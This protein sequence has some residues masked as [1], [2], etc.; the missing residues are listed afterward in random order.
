MRLL[1]N[2]FLEIFDESIQRQYDIGMITLA[3]T[4]L[5]N[6]GIKHYILAW[7]DEFKKYI[8]NENLIH[9]DWGE[10]SLKYPD[11]MGSSHTSEIGQKEVFE[12][13]LKKIKNKKIL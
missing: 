6:N 7:D 8:P 11:E 2:Y 12:K 13:I 5:K 10:L 3:H 1:K 9:I 4:L